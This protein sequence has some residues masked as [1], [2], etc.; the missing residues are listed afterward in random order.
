MNIH[1]L[2]TCTCTMYVNEHH[3]YVRRTKLNNDDCFR[4]LNTH[5]HDQI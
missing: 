1:A 4:V 3:G 5:L 2:G